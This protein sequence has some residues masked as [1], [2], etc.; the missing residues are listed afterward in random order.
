MKKIKLLIT[1]IIISTGLL[2]PTSVFANNDTTTVNSN[3]PSI[4]RLAGSDRYE[5]CNA[6]VNNG[7]SQSDYA[8]LVN[9]DMF[10]DAITASPLAKKLNNAPILLTEGNSLTASTKDQ[11][12]KLKVKN[13]YIIGGTGVISNSIVNTLNSMNITVKRIGGID[14]YET[15]IKVAKEL[16]G[17]NTSGMFVVSGDTFEDALSAAPIASKLQYPII[18][19]AKNYVPASVKNYAASAKDKDLILIGGADV[20]NSNISKDLSATKT[21]N[22]ADKYS[23]NLALI[24]DFKGNLDLSKV[25]VA[26]DSAFADALSGSA[27]AGK[28]ANPIILLGNS[29]IDTTSSF[30]SKNGVKTINVLGGRGV[31]SDNAAN[32]ITGT[33]T[34]CNSSLDSIPDNT[35]LTESQMEDLLSQLQGDWYKQI[36]LKEKNVTIPYN[37]KILHFNTNASNKYQFITAYKNDAQ[38]E[39]IQKIKKVSKNQYWFYGM[40]RTDEYDTL[41][42]IDID[43]NTITLDSLISKATG[44]NLLYNETF[45]KTDFVKSINTAAYVGKFLDGANNTY[46]FKDD[47]TAVWPNRT[48]KYKI[49]PLDSTGDCYLFEE[50][51]SNGSVVNR[52]V[53]QDTKSARIFY[54]AEKNPNKHTDFDPAYVKGAKY[55]VLTKAN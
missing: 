17:G 29:N 21:Y 24:N 30:I 20:L 10:A 6:I 49:E 41:F 50:Y 52:L 23:R 46:E 13:V 26:S 28:T 5:T 22:Q 32:G 25:L 34:V 3:K 44:S 9:S 54:V 11:L 51:D 43:N 2:L 33:T 45:V 39:I 31:I 15:S 27:L 16:T 47:L 19:V 12:Q 53:S 48:F 35:D 38:L 37:D 18:L 40:D 7:W 42:N 36:Y 14:R 4:T 55:L 1:S 8:I